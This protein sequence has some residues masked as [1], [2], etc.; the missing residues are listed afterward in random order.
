MR[1]GDE[2]WRV[3]TNVCVALAV[4]HN[5]MCLLRK[6]DILAARWRIAD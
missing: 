5:G 2:M 1:P 6:F 3:G 4:P